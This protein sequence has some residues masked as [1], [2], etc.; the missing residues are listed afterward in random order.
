MNRDTV[1]QMPRATFTSHQKVKAIPLTRK[2]YNDYRGWGQI[3]GEEPTDKGYLIE[4]LD[5]GGVQNDTRHRGYIT[6]MSEAQFDLGFKID[7]TPTKSIIR[8]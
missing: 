1:L 6:W 3:A 4:F 7:T 5:K 2:N 8:D